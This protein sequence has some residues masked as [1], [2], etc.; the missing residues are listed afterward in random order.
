M[1][2]VKYENSCDASLG[3]RTLHDQI[4]M[5]VCV[6]VR[7]RVCVRAYVCVCVLAC[8]RACLP[9]D[10]GGGGHREAVR[11]ENK[12]VGGGGGGIR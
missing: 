7:V 5:C 3:Y 12:H 8:L 11:L 4:R 6:R 10:G 1:A 2:S 9:A